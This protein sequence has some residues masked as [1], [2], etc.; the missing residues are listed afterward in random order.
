[1]ENFGGL[2]ENVLAQ[3]QYYA[4]SMDHEPVISQIGLHHPALTGVDMKLFKSPALIMARAKV[5]A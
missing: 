3:S 2:G 4:F 5:L 1:M